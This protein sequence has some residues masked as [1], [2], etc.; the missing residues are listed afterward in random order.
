MADEDEVTGEIP[1]GRPVL[2]ESLRCF[3]L[4]M[5]ARFDTPCS[6]E[7]GGGGG[8]GAAGTVDPPARGGKWAGE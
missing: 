2:G 8:G 3:P 7:E 4:T 1:A 5:S 6:A